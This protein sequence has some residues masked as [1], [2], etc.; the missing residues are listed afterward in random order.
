MRHIVCRYGTSI[1]V[2]ICESLNKK[3]NACE[4]TGE[5]CDA[6]RYVRADVAMRYARMRERKGYMLGKSRLSKKII[7][8]D[9]WNAIDDATYEEAQ[10]AAQRE[11]K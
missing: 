3:I 9:G 1:Q 11:G 6:T 5:D 2:G 8:H 4:P 7:A 10:Q